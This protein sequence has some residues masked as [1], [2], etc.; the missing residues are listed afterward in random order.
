MQQLNIIP[1]SSLAVAIALGLVSG[2]LGCNESPT[3]DLGYTADDLTTSEEP[4]VAALPPV[5][6]FASDFYG[7]WVGEADD[8]LA[9]Q[10][11]ADNSPPVYRFPSG[12]T[13]IRLEIGL[14]DELV[15]G[16]ITFGEGT[17]PAPPTDPNVGYPFDPDFN[18]ASAGALDGTLRPPLEGFAYTVRQ[19]LTLR[20]LDV[21]GVNYEDAFGVFAQGRVVDGKINVYYTP[22]ELFAPWCA[23]QTA[24]S[25]VSDQQV[26]WDSAGTQCTLGT[27]FTPIDCQKMA[28]CASGVCT[29]EGGVCSQSYDPTSD[30]TI[31]FSDEGELVG[32]FSGAVFVNERGFQQPLGTVRF[33]RLA[34]PTPVDEPESTPVE[35]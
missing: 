28:L 16:T 26:G 20:E 23:M 2:G 22:T 12:S 21:L 3:H 10:S 19:N 5:A 24:D 31:R 13:L 35:E 32:L 17:P 25:C 9:L 6:E 8:P 7:V 34:E 4:P 33:H 27:D 29:C 30:L 15:Q 11:N 14:G 1:A 18:M